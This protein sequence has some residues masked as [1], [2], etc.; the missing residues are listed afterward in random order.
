[1][2]LIFRVMMEPVTRGGPSFEVLYAPIDLEHFL[3]RIKLILI[4]PENISRSPNFFS[5]V[6]LFRE[7][8]RF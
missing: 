4:V 1:M 7:I 6:L 3:V 2:F 8:F 5:L